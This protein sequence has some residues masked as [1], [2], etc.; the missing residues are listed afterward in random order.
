MG[1]TDTAANSLVLKAFA[2]KTIFLGL[3]T[4]PTTNAGLGPEVSATSYIKQ[5]VTFNTSLNRTTSNSKAIT[6]PIA[7]EDWGI[8]THAA[9]IDNLGNMIFHGPLNTPQT[10]RKGDQVKIAIGE[11]SVSLR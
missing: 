3:Y 5:I 6:F 7:T 2:G 10:V 1:L 4:G 9:L 11:I 8:I